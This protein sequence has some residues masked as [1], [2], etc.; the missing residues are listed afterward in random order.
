M[1]LKILFLDI[2]GVLNRT[3]CVSSGLPRIEAHLAERLNQ[4]IQRTGARVVLSTTWRNWYYLGWL[5]LHGWKCLLG[6]HGIDCEVVGVLPRGDKQA[7]LEEWLGLRGQIVDFVVLDDKR[8]HPCQ[9][10]T[11]G[12]QG[13]TAADVEEAVRIL[14]ET[15][16][17]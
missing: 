16:C 3:P 1:P 12:Q 7:R 17:P 10:L 8:I 14:G 11:N 9:V 4:I 2:D 13:L 6:T 15:T 5:N